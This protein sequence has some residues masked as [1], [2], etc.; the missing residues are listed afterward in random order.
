MLCHAYSDFFLCSTFVELKLI[1]GSVVIIFYVY[2]IHWWVV[3]W[4]LSAE[5]SYMSWVSLLIVWIF[6]LAARTLLEKVNS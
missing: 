6:S 1:S 5:I 3:R 2:Y 4:S